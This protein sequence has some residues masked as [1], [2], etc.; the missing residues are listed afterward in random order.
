MDYHKL[1]RDALIFGGGGLTAIAMGPISIW[2]AIIIGIQMS[3]WYFIFA[4]FLEL[5]TE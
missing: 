4:V 5:V 3:L 1:L 2:Y